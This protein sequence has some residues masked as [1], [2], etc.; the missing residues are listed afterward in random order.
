VHTI[1]KKNNKIKIVYIL[2]ATGGGTR[3]HITQLLLQLDLKKFQPILFC[4]VK[5]DPAFLHDIRLL[6][7][8]GIEVKTF[9]INRSISPISD[10][11]SFF[12]ITKAL[13]LEKPDIVHTH[14]SKAGII[15][16]M[17]AKFAGVA[18]IAHT[19]H[20][21]PFEMAVGPL[22]QYFYLLLEKYTA[23]FTDM[24]IAVSK[25]EKHI[26]LEKK[27]FDK[28]H[29]TVIQNGID[30][31]LWINSKKQQKA[32]RKQT[33]ISEKEFIVGM[34]G[35]F[36]PQKGHFILIDAAEKLLSKYNNIKF[37]LIGDGAQKI[38]IQNTVLHRKIKQHFYFLNENDNIAPL[39][40]LFDCLVQPALWEGCPYVI[41][42]AMAMGVPVIANSVGGVPEIIKEG[43][44]ILIPPEKPE[45]LA[46]AIAKLCDNRKLAK[47]I[48]NKGRARVLKNFIHSEKIKQLEEIYKK[49]IYKTHKNILALIIGVFLFSI[50]CQA[51]TTICFEAED[52]SKITKPVKI[53]QIKDKI[54]A[55]KISKGKCIEIVQGAGSGTKAGG[56]ATYKIN[57]PEDGTYYFWARCWWIDSCGN[58]FSVK[59]ADKPLFTFGND[60]TY[61]RWHWVKAKIK[62]KLKKGKHDLIIKNREDGIKIDQILITNDRKVIP[63]DIEDSKKLSK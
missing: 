6:T 24:L 53:V 7:K 55:S 23:K 13:K 45:K 42:E 59:I 14:S 52:T 47:K 62:L 61:K 3:R 22:K 49:M 10:L 40:A 60:G 51:E 5:R 15:G 11:F 46:K 63:V 32:I 57:L 25:A 29:I 37:V 31:E 4:A 44:G 16:R 39:Y 8:H 35:R 18:K 20:V 17:A 21:F 34:V 2:E 56:S 36:M 43:T 33:G 27:L 54:I 50:Y 48:G 58:S 28:S 12:S 30:P 41:L 1:M 26:A 9:P 38:H 19:P